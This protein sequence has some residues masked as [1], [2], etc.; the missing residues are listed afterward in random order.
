MTVPIIVFTILAV[1]F[2]VVNY[3]NGFWLYTTVALLLIIT[4]CRTLRKYVIFKKL[5]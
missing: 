3:A 5:G 2:A 1:Q 4:V